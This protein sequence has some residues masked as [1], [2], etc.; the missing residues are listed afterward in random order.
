M[1]L[2][3]SALLLFADE[4]DK[5]DTMAAAYGLAVNRAVNQPTEIAVVG[6]VD[7]PRTQAL[8]TA[9]WQAFV[10]WRV[11]LPLDP[12]RQAEAIAARALP[13]QDVPAAYVC[14][15][16][17]CSAPITVPGELIRLLGGT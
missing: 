15:D 8:L 2:G 10:P 11:V 4:Y 1:R 6:T 12:T 7:D 3:E 14:H 16:Q 13:I 5:Y 9:A 17:T